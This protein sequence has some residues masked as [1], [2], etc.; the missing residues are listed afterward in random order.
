MT[1]IPKTERAC[2]ILSEIETVVLDFT[3]YDRKGGGPFISRQEFEQALK[4][5]ELAVDDIVEE[6]RKELIF[7]LM[8]DKLI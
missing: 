3:Y 1:R 7:N 5:G 4:N 8:A 2:E 6:F